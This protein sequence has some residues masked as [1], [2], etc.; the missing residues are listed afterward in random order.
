MIILVHILD[1]IS[2]VFCFW[3]RARIF[4]W[5]VYLFPQKK[6]Q[7]WT[8]WELLSHSTIRD[9]FYKKFATHSDFRK[10][11]DFS[12]K[13]NIFFSNDSKFWTFW[14]LLSI[15]TI[16]DAFQSFFE[17]LHFW[18]NSKVFSGKSQ[19]LNVLRIPEQKHNLR[20]IV[21]QTCQ[22]IQFWQKIQ[23]FSS[24]KPHFFFQENPK[25]ESF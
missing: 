19:F 5:T 25:F 15:I 17:L 2:H 7:F 8:F 9:A 13:E 24:E 4:F 11:Q 18:K 23:A 16:W 10:S 21:H 22:I 1:K 12:S 20:Q 6:N 3:K 14:E